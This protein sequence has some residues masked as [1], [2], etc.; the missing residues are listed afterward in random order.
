MSTTRLLRQSL[1]WI[2]GVVATL[3]MVIYSLL[4]DQQ[5]LS[6]LWF[7]W[8]FLLGLSLGSMLL[9]FIHNL[10]GGEWG[11]VVRPCLV[12][13]MRLIPLSA[14]FALPLFYSLNEFMP[15][16]RATLGEVAE[17]SAHK[18]WYLN[19]E[20]FT[21][22]G[23]AYFILWLLLLWLHQHWTN[24]SQ[25]RVQQLSAFGLVLL[26]VTLTLSQT[27]WMMSLTP[28]WYSTIGGMLSAV[29]FMLLALSTAILW[30]AW[31]KADQSAPRVSVVH[32][33][34]NLM[35]ALVLVWAYL[36]FM[37]FLIVWM[38]DLPDDVAWYGPRILTS[39][40]GLSVLV[41]LL[42]F[43][44]PMAALLSRQLKDSL[45][46]LAWVAWVVWIS[47]LLDT[48]WQVIPSLR[49]AGLEIQLNDLLALLALGGLW[50]AALLYLLRRQVATAALAEGEHG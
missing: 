26:A 28:A 14:L 36:A 33:L 42:H 8:Q 17:V 31:Q 12:V 30:L 35:M 34:G 4:S 20:F 1:A 41:A 16:I 11:E 25:Q 37:Q 45:P 13:V 49:P 48:Y 15:W 10:T 23:I 24:A 38:E 43:V 50:S 3:L 6:S 18:S 22:R 19:S 32:D 47:C 44:I 9:L 7:V 27:D 21:L 5:P 29:S 39:W 46:A 2:V 40:I